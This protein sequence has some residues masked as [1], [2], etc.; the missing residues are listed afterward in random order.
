M[1]AGRS[2]HNNVGQML[3]AKPVPLLDEDR[4]IRCEGFENRRKGRLATPVL[5]VKHGKFLKWKIGTGRYGI[6]SAHIPDEIDM[7]QHVD[8]PTFFNLALLGS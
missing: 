4:L 7:C 1:L 3:R 8:H 2:C 5:A 6:K